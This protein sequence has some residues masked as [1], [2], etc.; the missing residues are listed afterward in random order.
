MTTEMQHN[1]L[2]FWGCFIALIATAFGFVIRT[3]IIDDWGAEFNLSQT[4][5]GNLFGVGLYPFAISIVIW[6]LI[7]DRIGYKPAMVFGFVCHVLSAILT[8]TAQGYWGLYW[9]TFIVALGNGTVE[10]YINPV[11]ATIF[12]KEKTKWLN[13]L[14]AGWPGGLVLGGVLTII[15]GA[16]GTTEWRIKVFLLLVPVAI[17]FLM[18][19][20]EKFPLNERVA[21]GVSYKDMLREV[22][23]LGFFIIVLLITSEVINV[24]IGMNVMENPGRP[25]LLLVSTWVVSVILTA[26]YAFF[27]DFAPGRPLFIILLLIMIP[28]ATT[29][30][31]TDSWITPLMSTEMT[32]LG[33]DA[34]W[35]LV[36]TSAIMAVLRFCAGPIVHRLSPLGLLAV[37]ALLAAIGL[38]YLSTAAGFAIF[39]A[40][41]LYGAGK[42]F[43]WPTTLG[44]VSEQFPRGGALTLNGVAA[45]GMLG[46]GIIG[47]AFTGMVQDKAI[48]NKLSNDYPPIYAKI[49]GEPKPT[50]FGKVPAIDTTKEDTLTADEAAS[51]E[52]V[53]GGASRTALA[54]T[55][56]L[57]CIML[58]CYLIL[59]GYF[60]SKGGYEAE[61]LA[62]HAAEDEKFTGGVAG[63]MEG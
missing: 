54:I 34:G 21:A 26:V 47:A 50:I 4:E 25:P 9:A 46:V 42:T 35:V 10:A 53:R 49:N 5:K 19:I 40:A 11:V 61:T 30:L 39:I 3:M 63:P 44:V 2:I 6:S 7:I 52:D 20:R 24:L 27:C 14:H 29:E 38:Y 23:F 37:S 31:G 51:L 22:G 62:G 59:I 60:K 48:D 16:L 41:T 33:L 18:L 45:V 28:L 55:A 13:I 1:R 15:V 8:V 12:S 58:V 56:I 36:Y 57:P 32:K 17:Y 43:F